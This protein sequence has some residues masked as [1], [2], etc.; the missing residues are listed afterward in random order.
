MSLTSGSVTD[1]RTPTGT[2][3]GTPVNCDVLS[4]DGSKKELNVLNDN[5]FIFSKG[6]IV[7]YNTDSRQ[8]EGIYSQ[9][10]VNSLMGSNFLNKQNN[11][12]VIN[13]RNGMSIHIPI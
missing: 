5:G 3:G 1:V 4:L 12:I 10:P 8:I 9:S 6:D 7:L 2:P 11:F 13:Y